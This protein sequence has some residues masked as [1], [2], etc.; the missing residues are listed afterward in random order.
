M[1][2]FDFSNSPEKQKFPNVRILFSAQ[3]HRLL[4]RISRS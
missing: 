3:T 2:V 1:P 4:L